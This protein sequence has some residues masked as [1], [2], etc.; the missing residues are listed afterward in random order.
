MSI[1]TESQKYELLCLLKDLASVDRNFNLKEAT[2][3]R[4]IGLRLDLHPEKISEALAED[5]QPVSKHLEHFDDP[6]QRK[7]VYQQCLL[8]LM[9]DREISDEEQK[10][11]QEIKEHFQLD[12]LFH[13]QVMSW[14]KEGLE[15]EQKGEQLTGA[16][17]SESF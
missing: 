13:D 8:L 15:W 11:A 12:Q 3:I 9:S 2:R 7:F 4:L 6:V 16:S 10:A 14:V 17:F 5:Y 1:L